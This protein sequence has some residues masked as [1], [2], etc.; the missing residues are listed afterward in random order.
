[1]GT[2]PLE[3]FADAGPGLP[4]LMRVLLSHREVRTTV[5]ARFVD[6]SQFDG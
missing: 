6:N 1:M 4:D 2:P 5:E 3:G